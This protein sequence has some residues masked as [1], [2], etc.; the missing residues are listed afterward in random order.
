MSEPECQE[1]QCRVYLMALDVEKAA[2]LL[3]RSDDH[4]YTLPQFTAEGGM[5][6]ATAAAIQEQIRANFQIEGQVLY[7]AVYE[8]DEAICRAEAVI[9]LETHAPQSVAGKWLA[10][11]TLADVTLTEPKYCSLLERI[12][13]ELETGQVPAV[14]PPWARPGWQREAAAWMT[15][16]LNQRGWTPTGLP[17][18]VRSWSL[19]YVMRMEASTSDSAEKVY[20]A[21]T[22]WFYFKTSL[23]LPLFVN[24]AVVT[25][26]LAALFPG[27]IPCPTAV[28]AEN[29]WMVLEDFGT[30][31]GHEAPLEDRLQILEQYG[32]MQ[33]KSAELTEQLI[34]LGCIDRRLVWMARQ[35]E[36]LITH[37]ETAKALTVEEAVQLRRLVQPLRRMCRKLADFAIPDALIHGDLHGGN[38]AGKSGQ[39]EPLLF[40]DWTDSA[41]SHPFFDMLLIYIEKETA[42]REQMRDVYLAHW[43]DYEPMERLLESWRLAEVLASVY[44]AVSYLYIVEG[45]EDWGKKEMDWALPYWFRK[46]LGYG[47]FIHEH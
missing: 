45:V 9:V 17:E 38:V 21:E 29:N 31:I 32:A 10:R 7:R 34:A 16:E 13:G 2:V 24:E 12:L 37:P 46:I 27:H 44:H 30:M 41:V 5:W 26:E 23:D 15:A 40:F 39:T 1:W 14:R 11:H 35:I 28:E 3:H 36:P 18:L 8:E 19:S 42:E 6:E 47:E 33:V 4:T 43:L 20:S 22:Q 25:K